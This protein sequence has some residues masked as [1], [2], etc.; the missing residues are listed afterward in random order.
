MRTRI[1]ICRIA[2]IEEALLA[3]RCGA[4]AIGLVGPTV[5]VADAQLGIRRVDTTWA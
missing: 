1:R 4:D 5:H 3:T 2:S